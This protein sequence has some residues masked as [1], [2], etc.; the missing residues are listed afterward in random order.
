MTHKDLDVWKLSLNLVENIYKI[1][2]AFPDDEKFGLIS[3]MRRC[4]T[5]IPSNIAEGSARGTTRE[6]VR[7]LQ[8]ARGSLAELVTQLA[9]ATRL[10]YIVND[11]ELNNQIIPISKML[12]KLVQKLTSKIL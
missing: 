9:I 5:S 2:R 12:Y 8:I 4:S 7:F 6:F 10:N 3:Q 11:S 1:T